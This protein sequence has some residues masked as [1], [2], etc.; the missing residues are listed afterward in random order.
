MQPEDRPWR[1]TL[2]SEARGFGKASKESFA[3]LRDDRLLPK[4][5]FKGATMFKLLQIAQ[6]VEVTL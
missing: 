3:R 5:C 4:G 1:L 6:I 2:E